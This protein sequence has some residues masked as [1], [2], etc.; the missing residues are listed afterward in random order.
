VI[1]FFFA[2]YV[3]RGVF[4]YGLHYF[5]GSLFTCFWSFTSHSPH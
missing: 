4:V 3:E 1:F 5:V 2:Q